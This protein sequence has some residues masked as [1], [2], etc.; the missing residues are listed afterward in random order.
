LVG[1]ETLPA[2]LAALEAAELIE[3]AALD[4]AELAGAAV[5]VDVLVLVLV[6]LLLP[7]PAAN[8]P[9]AAIAASEQSLLVINP[10]M[11]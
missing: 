4:T 3:D 11:G 2:L 8:A 5:D 1:T 6:L 10:P 9:T 7:Q